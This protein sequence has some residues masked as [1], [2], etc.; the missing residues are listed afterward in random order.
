M[1]IFFSKSKKNK[2]FGG[3]RHPGEAHSESNSAKSFDESQ[4]Q[5]EAFDTKE[6]GVRTVAL[7]QIVG[8]V[9][10]YHDFDSSFRLRSHMPSE[11]LEAVKN[12]MRQGKLMPPVKLY[13]IKDEYYALD[14]NH[15]IAAAHELGYTDIQARIVEFIPSKKTIGNILYRERSEFEEK[16]KLLFKIILTE[17]GQYAYLQQ[18]IERHHHYLQE[19][20]K[21]PI[22]FEQAAADWHHTIYEPMVALIERTD[23]L[24]SFPQRTVADLFAYM[25]YHQWEM[26]RQRSYG[27]GIADMIPHS[28]EEF[29]EKMRQMKKSEYPEM[30]RGITAF[31][32]MKVQ[33]SRE[34]KII[35]KLFA[36]EE[37]R[38]IHSVH[39]DVDMIV[40]IV[41]T[42][43]LLSSDSEVISQFVHN[44]IRLLAGV[45]STQT[46]IPGISRIK[47]N[48]PAR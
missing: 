36:H 40:K 35:D 23:L 42:R 22:Q 43:D 16:T 19:S 47:D 29:R 31:I 24:A 45:I 17:L 10:R 18:Q 28:M 38:E 14:G 48:A 9:G 21:V 7:D 2:L 20:Q 25:S 8:S 13:Q 37:V 44:K 33:A 32:L 4:R 3:S 39:G 11:R 15:R 1:G 6:R 30:H 5:E 46:L 41:L 26:K 12:A 34:H 27:I